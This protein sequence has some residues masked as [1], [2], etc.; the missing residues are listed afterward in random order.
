MCNGQS[1]AY[2]K[3]TP[4]HGAKN[5][6][7]DFEKRVLLFEDKDGQHWVPFENV[8]RGTF[9][10]TEEPKAVAADTPRRAAR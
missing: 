4:A 9:E 3:D 10:P 6:R 8:S 7:A 1:A 2:L 5:L